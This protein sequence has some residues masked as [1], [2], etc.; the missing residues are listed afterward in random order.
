VLQKKGKQKTTI[1]LLQIW[2]GVCLLPSEHSSSGGYVINRRVR[3]ELQELGAQWI[4]RGLWKS[5]EQNGWS[6]SIIHG[7]L[8]DP[9]NRPSLVQMDVLG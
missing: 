6:F 9:T 1:H 2:K 5:P 4:I 7:R 8:P 3:E